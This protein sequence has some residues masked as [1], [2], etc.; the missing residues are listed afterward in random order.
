MAVPRTSDDEGAALC[1]EALEARFASPD[2]AA[3]S[4]WFRRLAARHGWGLGKVMRAHV[5]AHGV[6][7]PRRPR[8]ARRLRER[9]RWG[10]DAAIFLHVAWREY[11]VVLDF[12][13]EVGG[14]SG[15]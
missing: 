14:S 12:G 1:R 15:R 4:R 3:A 11:G 9:L 5:Y 10:E 8:L 13:Q 7:V 6:G 2:P